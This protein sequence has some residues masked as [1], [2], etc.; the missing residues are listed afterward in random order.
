MKNVFKKKTLD[1]GSYVNMKTGES[2]LDERPDISSVNVKTD[3]V[4]F[5]SKEFIVVDSR[6]LAYVNA[7]F[8][9]SD[10][11][12]I[13]EMADM[14]RTCYNVLF[15]RKKD[16]P[17]SKESLMEEID[18][19]RNKY[20]AFLRKLL[21]HNIIYYLV[22]MKNRRK[23]VH[24]ML[25]PSLARKSKAFSK[26]CTSVFANLSEKGASLR[27]RNRIDAFEGEKE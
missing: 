26:E 16:V 12:K 6:A 8:N 14:V 5:H 24:I 13:L 2:L 1:L 20:E 4:I 11:A 18:I 25:N 7:T 21:L 9:R 19:T 15:D 17:H 22:G 27:E 23:I 10:T 3:L